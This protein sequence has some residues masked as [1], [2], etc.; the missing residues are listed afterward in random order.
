[1][2]TKH[3]LSSDAFC[4]GILAADSPGGVL[5]GNT[6]IRCPVQQ[7]KDYRLPANWDKS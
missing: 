5:A 2:K 3:A 7:S 6:I 4:R 1:M